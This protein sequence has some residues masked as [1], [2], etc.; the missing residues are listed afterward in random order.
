M[1]WSADPELAA[2]VDA[3]LRERLT[4][5]ERG[6]VALERR[7]AGP[8]PRDVLVPLQRDAHTIKGT[9]RMAGVDPMVGLAHRLED[10]LAA[11]GDGRVAVSREAID[12]ALGMVTSLVGVL[13]GGAAAAAP[14][15]AVAGGAAAARPVAEADGSLPPAVEPAGVDAL[16]VREHGTVVRLPV[17]RVHDLLDAVGDTEL[18]VRRLVREARSDPADS[19]EELVL[20]REAREA[21]LASPSPVPAAATD[22]LASLATLL[23]RRAR[24]SRDRRGRLEDAAGR[25]GRVRE[26]A[27][28]LAT[29]PVSRVT[30][31]LERLVRDVAAATGREVALAV[32]GHEVELDV[33]V[34]DAVAESLRHLVT[35]AVD[36]GCEPP[37][38]RRALGKPPRA[39]VTVAARA[40]GPTVVLE[41]ADDG[42]GVDVAAVRARATA[43]GR[44]EPDAPDD[45]VLRVLLEPGFSTRD[46]V[47]A[48][49]GRGVGLDVVRE[50]VVA[51]GGDVEVVSTPGQG[52]RVVLTL[53]VT[54]G[55]A[56]TLVVRAAGERWAV[57][58]G[59]V[60]ETVA[61]TPGVVHDLAG[62]RVV[63]HRGEAVPLLD[64]AAA[65]GSAAPSHP[66]VA[67]VAR[68][69]AG[70]L[71]AWAVD[72]V[73]AERETVV[74]DL[75]GFLGRRDGV[76]GATIDDDGRVLALL[77]L[78][79]LVAVS[80]GGPAPA[81]RRTA[82]LEGPG[83]SPVA[84]PGRRA[85][86][87]VVEDSV[88]VRELV[89]SVL[90]AAGY[91]VSTAVDG[92]DGAARLA[93]GPVDLVV[94]DV[95]MPGM[96]GVTLTRTLRATR[97]WEHVPVVILTSRRG[98]A[99]R[100]AG[101]DAGADA[102]LLKAD[103]APRTLADTVARLLAE[104]RRR[105]P[106]EVAAGAAPA[107][108]ADPAA[109]GDDA[110]A[111]SPAPAPATPRRSP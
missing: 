23:D 106:L 103:F 91:A 84:V 15:P 105:A 39:T 83:P 95:E 25:L 78:R 90:E 16:P 86:V 41:V 88:G 85:R 29:A 60:L 47:T 46:A 9:A 99:D 97:G 96:D 40:A 12:E 94:T 19:D 2:L 24:R 3:E 20:L 18:A 28:G 67:V 92:L 68:G 111:S 8:V 49:S 63:M 66:R 30:G 80:G 52:T 76:L 53:P 109:P 6:L 10:L 62:G 74:K 71:R 102:Y 54:L 35:N 81:P 7:P 51:L 56:H 100:R 32:E 50:A 43:M 65:V 61:L 93:G 45:A 44:I 72:V 101:M 87:L 75:G 98:E 110:L 79:A 69:R 77:D 36:H 107:V 33:R 48:E 37:E 108:P 5:L 21:L 4:S 58:L 59:A 1:T 42:R 38:E 17:D 82:S 14:S 26:G 104:A 89:R 27:L 31:G 22:A 73:E 70:S 11:L 13:P 64:L 57:P 55:I 34:L